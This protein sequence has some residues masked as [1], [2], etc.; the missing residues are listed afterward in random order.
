MEP[1]FG[2]D[3]SQ[4]RI[5]NDETAGDSAEAL[6]ANAYTVHNHIAFAPG[7]FTPRTEHGS[8]LLAHELTHV[9]QQ[10]TGSSDTGPAGGGI[11]IS[12]P[13]D[14]SEHTAEGI[15]S[16]QL[17]AR[18]AEPA[19]TQVQSGNGLALV[20]REPNKKKKPDSSKDATAAKAPVASAAPAERQFSGPEAWLFAE[21][22]IITELETRYEEL[23]RFGAYQ[24]R[25]QIKDFFDPYE[26]DLS[27]DATFN[28]ILGIAGGGAGNVPNDPAAIQPLQQGTPP[29]TPHGPI[30]ATA[31]VS[32]GVAGGIAA[33]IGP[34]VNM[35]LDASSVADVK[36][37]LQSDVDKFIAQDLT[38]SSPTYSAFENQARDEMRQYF[39]NEWSDTKRPHDATDLSA[40][41]NQTA[42]HARK[43]YGLK[44]SVGQQVTD[45]IQKYVQQQLDKLQ[46]VLDDL[47]KSHRRKRYLGFGLGAGLAGGLIGGAI[48]FAHGGA[49]GLLA[50]AGIGLLAGGAVGA[51]AA[52]LT[53]LFTDTAEDKR[54]KKAAD[55]EKQK[56]KDDEEFKKRN[57]IL[58]PEYRSTKG[59]ITV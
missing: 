14:R 41:I 46:P 54:K 29:S 23:V 50:G 59:E 1:R 6:G 37:N 8:R 43:S 31:S 56:K 24:T 39:L 53:N 58:E 40:L 51:G 21:N 35:I 13:G 38:T 32:G 7:Q 55:E 22:R 4:V 15:A 20:Q 27:A 34:L 26:D 33:S 11:E 3:F 10:G 9:V 19:A 25:D 47:E 2:Q 42:Q 18:S 12:S 49:G 48:G 52:F 5:H 16:G 28:T 36:K 45:A 57:F 17:D 30:P 44:S